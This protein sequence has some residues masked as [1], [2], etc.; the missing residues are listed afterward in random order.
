MLSVGAIL[1]AVYALLSDNKIDVETSRRYAQSVRQDSSQHQEAM[2][3]YLIQNRL[4]EQY[5]E[6]A[7]SMLSQLKLQGKIAQQQYESQ[8]IL[9]QSGIILD[10]ITIH[11]TLKSD[12]IHDGHKAVLPEMFLSLDNYGKRKALD[13]KVDIN[14]YSPVERFVQHQSILTKI[15][16]PS[17]HQEQRYYPVILFNDAKL[18]YSEICIHWRDELTNKL[19]SVRHNLEWTRSIDYKYFYH[20]MAPEQLSRVKKNM[21][22]W[23]KIPDAS[24]YLDAVQWRIYEKK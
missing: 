10:V 16:E 4:M 2:G 23:V 13:V 21:N 14:F 5:T 9:N 15:I 17:A 22:T 8:V 6:N 11:D 12:I 7:D 3:M 1:I 18:F 19:D 24:T 20:I